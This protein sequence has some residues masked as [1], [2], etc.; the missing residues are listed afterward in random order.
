MNAQHVISDGKA[1]EV[2]G[3]SIFSGGNDVTQTLDQDK[4]DYIFKTHKNQVKANKKA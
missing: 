2:K 1:F 4:K 3:K